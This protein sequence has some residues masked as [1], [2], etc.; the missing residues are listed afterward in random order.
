MTKTEKLHKHIIIQSI[1]LS[2][3]LFHNIDNYLLISIN[4]YINKQVLFLKQKEPNAIGYHLYW[5][6]FLQH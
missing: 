5:P 6:S 2:G 4:P 1:L 3:K